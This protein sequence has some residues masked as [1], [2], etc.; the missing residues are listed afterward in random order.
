MLPTRFVFLDALPL[1]SIGKI[2]RR[3][4]PEPGAERAS[5]PAGHRPLDPVEEAVS[6][7]WRRVLGSAP[8]SPDED[9]F[10]W[11]GD[12]LQAIRLLSAL[13]RAFRIDLPMDALLDAAT[14]AGIARALEAREPRPGH[15]ARAASAFAKLQAMTESASAAD[16]R[17]GAG[18]SGEAHGGSAGLV[19]GRSE[20]HWPGRRPEGGGEPQSAVVAAG[21]LHRHPRTAGGE[22]PGATPVNGVER[23]YG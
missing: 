2:D 15:A 21:P 13:R 5:A 10:D 20:S 4:L 7:V 9:F 14:I 3:A 16:P 8:H 23:P 1:T 19:E 6:G 22:R 12:S 17:A 11:G 18:V